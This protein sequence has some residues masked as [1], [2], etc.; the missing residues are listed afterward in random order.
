MARAC[1]DASMT[2]ARSPASRAAARRA[3]SSGAS[4]V[5]FVPDS[6]PMTVVGCPAWRRIAA[7]SA[8]VVVLPFVPVTPTTRSARLG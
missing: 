4:G 1:D 8:H 6:V 3:W 2:T 5:V 7:S